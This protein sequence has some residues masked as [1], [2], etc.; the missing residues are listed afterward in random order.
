MTLSQ[1][2]SCLSCFQMPSCKVGSWAQRWWC[3]LA[4][5]MEKIVLESGTHFKCEYKSKSEIKKSAFLPRMKGWVC[6]LAAGLCSLDASCS[7]TQYGLQA[8]KLW[9]SHLAF[10]L[11]P[12]HGELS[13]TMTWQSPLLP[14]SREGMRHKYSSSISSQKSHILCCIPWLLFICLFL[15]FSFSLSC[16]RCKNLTAWVTF[17]AEHPTTFLLQ[18]FG[19]CMM[20]VCWEGEMQIAQL[21]CHP[22]VSMA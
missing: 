15:V 3:R 12:I 6:F 7:L 21:T 10:R 1:H 4:G 22:I 16:C 2:M 13:C 20:H 14:L 9:A 5:L 8:S 18:A 17:G 11:A 19:I